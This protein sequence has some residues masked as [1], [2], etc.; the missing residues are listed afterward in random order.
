M[1]PITAIKKILFQR[2]SREVEQAIQLQLLPAQVALE[3]L[4]FDP[5]IQAKSLESRQK[6]FPRWAQMLRRHPTVSA[7]YAG[8]ANGDFILLR[9][10]PQG[11]DSFQDLKFPASSRFLGQS[12]EWVRG[13]PQGTYLFLDSALQVVQRIPRPI[14]K[15][16][17]GPI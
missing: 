4:L 16:C 5:L 15:P 1:T 6:V 2:Q 10:L 7:L 8:Y 11:L 12:M 13:V 9:P 3:E 17:W 14:R